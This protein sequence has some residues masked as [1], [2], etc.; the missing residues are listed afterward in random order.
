M[1]KDMKNHQ[2]SCNNL[3][4]FPDMEHWKRTTC[5]GFLNQTNVVIPI[6]SA[7]HHPN[8]SNSPQLIMKFCHIDMRWPISLLTMIPQTSFFKVILCVFANIYCHRSTLSTGHLEQAFA[9]SLV[10]QQLKSTYDVFAIEVALPRPTY[11]MISTFP[12]LAL[13]LF[14]FLFLSFQKEL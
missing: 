14:L 11:Q 9:F 2:C 12:L 8:S 1:V 6:S 13:G 3:L 7:S 5:G 10:F 4:L